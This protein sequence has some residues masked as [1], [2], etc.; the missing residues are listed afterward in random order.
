MAISA[1]GVSNKFELTLRRQIAALEAFMAK[2]VIEM[3]TT[4]GNLESSANN[5]TRA[6]IIRQQLTS[7]LNRLGF[8]TN[9]RNLYGDIATSIEAEVGSD[10]ESLKVGEAVLAS[11]ATDATRHLDNAW[12]TM[13]GQ[14]QEA[15]EQAMLT[16]APIGDLVAGIAGPGRGT[17]RLTADLSAPF[18][19]W[20]NW[21]GAAVDTAISSMNRRIQIIGAT[22]AGVEYFIYQGTKIRTTRPFCRLMQ[23]VVV[24]L[25]D[26]RAIDN[27]PAL[28]NIRKLRS[29]DGRQPP[30]LPSL[31]GWRCRHTL[32]ATSLRDAQ[33][34]GRVVFAESKKAL[35]SEAGA[36]L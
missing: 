29:K 27:D 12:F 11:F 26:L 17:I 33:E 16:N 6:T 24:R 15:V 25:E 19:S 30:I 31:G 5:L 21:A 36:L 1:E 4:D 13:T 34:D 7:E 20:I 18:R 23:G 3:D 8:Q 14:I 35:N 22:E 28:S 10:K 2:L 9:V 32:T